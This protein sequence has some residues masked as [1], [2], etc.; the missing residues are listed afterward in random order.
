MAVVLA[1]ALA[2]SL[3]VI[4]LVGSIYVSIAEQ[5]NSLVAAGDHPDV[6]AALTAMFVEYIGVPLMYLAGLVIVVG[7]A[8]NWVK[9]EFRGR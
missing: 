1:I 7:V 5:A 2:V 8:L 9:R 3:C 4:S 6:Y